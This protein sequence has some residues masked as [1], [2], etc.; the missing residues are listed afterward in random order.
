MTAKENK[1]RNVMRTAGEKDTILELIQEDQCS[2]AVKVF[3]VEGEGDTRFSSWKC[4]W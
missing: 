1:G 2:V 3:R 4:G